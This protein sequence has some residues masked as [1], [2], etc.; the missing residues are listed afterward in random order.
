MPL[1]EFRCNECQHQFT[2]LVSNAE[3]SSAVCPKCGSGNLKQLITPFSTG[4]GFLGRLLGGS[5]GS[6]CCG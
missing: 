4:K 1:F 6:G 5:R 3:K 2:L